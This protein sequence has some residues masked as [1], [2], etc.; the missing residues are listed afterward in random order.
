MPFYMNTLHFDLRNVI[1]LLCIKFCIAG[2]YGNHG[3]QGGTMIA[4]FS[5]IKDNNGIDTEE[6]YPYKA[7]VRCLSVIAY[8]QIHSFLEW[9]L[10]FHSTISSS[11]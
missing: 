3:C 8:M 9:Y 4:S 10:S 6:S 7:D 1:A 11:Y 5:Y 2:K